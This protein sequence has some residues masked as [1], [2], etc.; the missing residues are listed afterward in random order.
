MLVPTLETLNDDK[1]PN[2]LSI[3]MVQKQ[4][5]IYRTSNLNPIFMLTIYF[6]KYYSNKRWTSKNP[7]LYCVVDNLGNSNIFKPRYFEYTIMFVYFIQSN[8]N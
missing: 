7:S 2:S 8:L 5:R 4:T 3:F 6:V 1:T